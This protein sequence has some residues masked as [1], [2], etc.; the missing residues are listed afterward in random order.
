MYLGDYVQESVHGKYLVTSTN[1]NNCVK[2]LNLQ[3][4][5]NRTCQNDTFGVTVGGGIGDFIYQIILQSI[6]MTKK[7][8]LKNISTFVI[9]NLSSAESHFKIRQCVIGFP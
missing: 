1:G 8:E 4:H 6:F 2:K 9:N 7:Y 3:H 5:N